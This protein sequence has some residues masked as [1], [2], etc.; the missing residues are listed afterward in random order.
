M[1]CLPAHTF[2]ALILCMAAVA[3]A[4][5]ADSYSNQKILPKRAHL[6]V[7][8]RATKQFVVATE[9]DFQWPATVE[10]I[11]GQWLW[12]SD[13]G[14][15]SP[16]GLPTNGWVSKNDVILLDSDPLEHGRS[17]IDYF[18]EQ[19]NR[20]QDTASA[21]LWR[22][23]S[24]ER[25]GE[26]SAAMMDY[27]AATALDPQLDEAWAKL[28]YRECKLA[29][30]THWK[31]FDD[32]M[33]KGPLRLDEPCLARIREAV[34]HFSRAI[35]LKERPR[36]YLRWANSLAI[37]Q[38]SPRQRAISVYFLESTDQAPDVILRPG[39]L[40][41]SCGSLMQDESACQKCSDYVASNYAHARLPLSS[42]NPTPGLCEEFSALRL[43]N[44]AIRLFPGF[45]DAHAGR[46]GFFEF[47]ADC[48]I[49]KGVALPPCNWRSEPMQ[50]IAQA[51]D[52][53]RKQVVEI[54]KQLK[55]VVAEA[56]SIAVY[57]AVSKN[58]EDDLKTRF[59][60]LKQKRHD[61]CDQIDTLQKQHDH[62]RGARP[63]HSAAATTTARTNAPGGL[64]AQLQQAFRNLIE[65]RKWL[66][67]VDREH[68]RLSHLIQVSIAEYTVALQGDPDNFELQRDLAS[69]LMML[70]DPTGF[71]PLNQPL[72][73]CLEKD[74][75][76]SR[77][78][79]LADSAASALDYDSPWVLA[80]LARVQ[81][82]KG[83]YSDA[84]RREGQ[85]LKKMSPKEL[86]SAVEFYE[87]YCFNKQFANE[88]PHCDID[89]C[90]E[91]GVAAADAVQRA[92]TSLETGL[93][94]AT[95]EKSRGPWHLPSQPTPATPS[96][97]ETLPT[98]M[99]G[100]SK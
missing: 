60:T 99:V 70:V 54:D 26:M 97:T 32:V 65:F 55:A 62:L 36:T 13:D 37:E 23:L 64:V 42:R 30:I 84:V 38:W 96:P 15:S 86:R 31:I 9:D 45:P 57:G 49:S 34:G 14:R 35:A 16:Q 89:G 44:R 88:A 46:G 24:F 27:S 81:N 11:D 33:L 93:K 2:V 83:E 78:K 53:A 25:N 5:G 95:E 59:A 75:V 48:C 20:D 72:N 7:M 41:W 85:A 51:I 56:E 6:L 66:D 100:P 73:R 52:S 8:D 10:R 61:L 4:S 17:A 22:G 94:S 82:A 63:E 58:W 40:A 47:Q 3:T 77:A 29:Q 39:D 92:G 69:V 12:I 98:P 90:K 21:H 18:T 74:W 68:E 19:I 87:F 71:C 1:F 43:Y 80:T 67:E 79:S 28:A 76:L 91:C 50:K